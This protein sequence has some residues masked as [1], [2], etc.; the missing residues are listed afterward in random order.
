MNAWRDSIHVALMV[1]NEE[2]HDPSDGAL[3]YYNFNIANPAWGATFNELAIFGNH[4]FMTD[5]GVK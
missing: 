2:G 3:Y 5:K 1:I 4:R